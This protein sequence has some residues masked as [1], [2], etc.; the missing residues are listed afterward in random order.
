MD[1]QPVEQQWCIGL[2]KQKISAS[3]S[4]SFLTHVF[5]YVLGAQKNR[6]IDVVL[7]CSKELSHLCSS[8]E[9]PQ[10]VLDEK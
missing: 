10:R 3:I 9:Y 8:F 7:L 1:F 2:D 4:K 6:L 5:T